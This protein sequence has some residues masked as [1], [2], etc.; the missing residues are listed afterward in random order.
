MEYDRA[1]TTEERTCVFKTSHLLK[2]SYGNLIEQPQDI[3]CDDGTIV[4]LLLNNLL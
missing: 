2:D 3:I 4:A 1:N